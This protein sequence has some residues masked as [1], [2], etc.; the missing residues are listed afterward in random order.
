MRIMQVVHL[1]A[2]YLTQFCARYKRL[3]SFAARNIAFLEDYYWCGHMLTPA[4]AR[5]GH[6][7][8][9]RRELDNFPENDGAR[10]CLSNMCLRAARSA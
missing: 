1:H 9:L 6:E 5:M 8:F 7:T 3:N 4:L 2:P 10:Q